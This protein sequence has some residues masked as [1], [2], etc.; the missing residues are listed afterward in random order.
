MDQITKYKIADKQFKSRAEQ[1]SKL[2]SAA[3]Q[4]HEIGIVAAALESATND[5]NWLLIEKLAALLIKARESQLKAKKEVGQLVDL[6]KFKQDILGPICDSIADR[7]QEFCPEK[8][9]DIMD[10]I[11]IDIHRIIGGK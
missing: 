3:Q 7:V 6:E 5:K 11:E 9:E 4:K 8:F 10:A 1:L 2:D